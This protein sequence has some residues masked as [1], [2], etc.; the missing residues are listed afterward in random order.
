MTHGSS[1]IALVVCFQVACSILAHLVSPLIFP[2]VLS[3]LAP[4]LVGFPYLMASCSLSC[5]HSFWLFACSVFVKYLVLPSEV[6]VYSFISCHVFLLPPMGSFGFAV[7]S[8]FLCS[9]FLPMDF[10]F[11]LVSIK[12]LC[13]P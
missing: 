13:S 7:C 8:N 2:S 3:C 4:A 9:V 10:C 11:V 12:S 5:A 1:F 6:H